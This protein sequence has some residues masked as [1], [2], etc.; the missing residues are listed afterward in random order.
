MDLVWQC[1]MDSSF[2]KKLN[3]SYCYLYEIPGELSQL[4]FLEELSLSGNKFT[5]LPDSLCQL[6]KLKVLELKDCTRLVALKE[7]PTSIAMLTMDNCKSLES[8]GDMLTTKYKWLH[9]VSFSNCFKLTKNEQRSSS[10]RSS[11]F[12]DMLLRTMLQVS[13]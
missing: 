1:L 4:Y 11:G 8:L 7:L 13:I 5:C 6:S 3:L 9:E 10:S 12:A 2:I